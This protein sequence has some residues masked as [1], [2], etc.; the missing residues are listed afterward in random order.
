MGHHRSFGAAA[1]VC[2][3]VL[4][5]PVASA[6][7]NLAKHHALSLVGTPKYGPDFTHFDWVN[8]N[9]PKGG[10]VRQWTMGSFDSLN[11]FPVKGSRGR[12]AHHDLRHADDHQPRRGLTEYGLLAEWVSY[13]RRL[14]LGHLSAAPA[15]AASMTASRSRRRTSSSRSRRIKK[16]SPQLRLLLQE[17]DEG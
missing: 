3:L 17:R 7:D 11:Q 9:A 15:S 10:R 1:F 16:A 5:A 8:P 12:R 6:S 4:G 2:L 14:L 13:P